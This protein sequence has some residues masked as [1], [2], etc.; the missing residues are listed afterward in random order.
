MARM[1]K[2]TLVLVF[3]AAATLKGSPYVPQAPAQAPADVKPGS[4]NCEECPYPHPKS[5]L[6]LTLVAFLR[7]GLK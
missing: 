1:L 6:A 7:E 3:A 4:I 5:Y 2:A